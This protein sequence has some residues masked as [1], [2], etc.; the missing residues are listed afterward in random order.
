MEEVEALEWFREDYVRN[1]LE[2][3]KNIAIGLNLTNEQM[4]KAFQEAVNS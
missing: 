4:L 2:N 3:A 1:T